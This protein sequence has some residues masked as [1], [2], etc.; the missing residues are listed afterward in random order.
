MTPD[1]IRLVHDGKRVAAMKQIR[2][3]KGTGLRAAKQMIDD[4][5][6]EWSATPDSPMGSSD[7]S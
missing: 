4:Y 1:E 7:V 2:K 5:L 6:A 3:R